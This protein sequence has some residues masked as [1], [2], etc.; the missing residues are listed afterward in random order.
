MK[1]RLGEL[2]LE[3]RLIDVNQL[4]A[5]LAHQRQW[6]IRLGAALVANGFI[7]EG[8]LM[9]VLSD[10]LG[11]PMVDLSKVVL[12]KAALALVP[13]RVCEQYEV[14]P[15][16]VREPKGGR[17]TLLLAMA[18]PL[19]VTA[20]DEVAFLS[21]CIIKVGIAQASSID[22][23]I[24]RHLRGRKIEIA[25]MNFDRPTPRTP[26]RTNM[27]GVGSSPP[28]DRA[29]ATNNFVDE[30]SDAGRPTPLGQ[31]PMQPQPH[32][33]P[34]PLFT[35]VAPPPPPS[36]TLMSQAVDPFA[37]LDAYAG[38]PAGLFAMSP[39]IESTSPGLSTS[40]LS[41]APAPTQSPSSDREAFEAL[42]R[43]FWALMRVLHRR[44]QITREE[45]VAEL[46]EEL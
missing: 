4:T 7:A 26:S 28:A 43:K 12:D 10:A 41:Q 45:F 14:F 46:G 24:Q 21:D 19:N 27:T 35:P 2:L 15:I 9:Q 25:P 40:T 23:A 18:D 42:E 17:R 8:T 36:S 22:Q 31:R 20:V 29:L 33:P 13:V 3:K 38:M 32:L 34:Q 5:A 16:A 1:K 6:G 37:A 44:G 39:P 11:L 30:I